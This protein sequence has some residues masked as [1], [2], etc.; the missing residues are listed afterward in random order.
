MFGLIKNLF[1]KKEKSTLPVLTTSNIVINKNFVEIHPDIIEYLWFENGERKNYNQNFKQDKNELNISFII[2]NEEPSLINFDYPVNFNTKYLPTDEIGYFPSYKGLTAEEKGIYLKWLKN[3]F[4]NTG[5][6]IGYVFLLLYGLERFLFLKNDQQ[7]FD[8]ILRLSK[9]YGNSSF[10]SY[11]IGDLIAYSLVTKSVDSLSKIGDDIGKEEAVNLKL[12]CKIPL[13]SFDIINMCNKVGFSNKRY[14][15]NENNLFL[16]SLDEI[17]I[18]RYGNAE[19]SLVKYDY[20][21]MKTKNILFPANISLRE[22]SYE[23][24]DIT[25]NKEFC[26]ELYF[27]LSESHEYTKIK[28]SKLRKSGKESEKIKQQQEIVIKTFDYKKEEML[29][30]KL[31]LKMNAID[32]HFVYL[33]LQNFYYNYRTIDKK[34]IEECIKWCNK[35]IENLEELTLEHRKNEIK[36][37]N[38]YLKNKEENKNIKTIEE[39]NNSI[40]YGNIPTFE[41]LAIIYDKRKEYQKAIDIC[42]IAKEYYKREKVTENF[43]EK[44]KNFRNRIEKL[45]KINQKIKA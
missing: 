8:L 44:I 36:N 15:K 41:R 23:I 34:Y 30:K 25:T 13:N 37:R 14:I 39:I 42:I 45:K 10:N 5:I 32:A 29:L 7:A 4:E 6:C 11:A 27:I 31:K 35:D 3:P 17:L 20:N 1:L 19:Y 22:I 9:I 16:E 43:K 12:I 21:K 28:L 38:F 24:P 26:D 40:F 33:E 18:K 2:D